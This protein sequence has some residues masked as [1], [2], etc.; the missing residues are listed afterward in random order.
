MGAEL[1]A[2]VANA[3]GSFF[4]N[5]ANPFIQAK[6]NKDSREWQEKMYGLQRQ[7]ALEDRDY[8]N[9]YNSPA[10][11]MRRLK[12]AGLNPNLVY[13]HGADA[14]MGS[15]RSSSVGGWN[16]TA[17]QVSFSDTTQGLGAIYDMRMKDA[18]IDNLAV[19]RDVQAQ[20]ILLK[21]AQ[22]QS[23]LSDWKT[24]DFDLK[25][26]N[27]LKSINMEM[28]AESLQKVKN[29]V[30]AIEQDT[31]LKKFTFDADVKKAYQDLDNAKEA[32]ELTKHQVL[33]AKEEINILKKEGDLKEFEKNLRRIGIDTSSPW[34]LKMLGQLF[35]K[36]VPTP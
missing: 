36:Y 11:Q 14:T 1:F 6:T 12:A 20:E 31:S 22:T 5:I 9:Q 16:P 21:A 8:E 3:M 19:V 13:G 23:T 25:M 28:A 4:G 29:E 27:D 35:G 18:Q 24:K 7:H 30:D 26:K 10:E 34:Y 15:T 32:G 2:G 17:P 33:K